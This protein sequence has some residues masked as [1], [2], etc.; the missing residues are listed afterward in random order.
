MN[1]CFKIIGRTP[2]LQEIIDRDYKPEISHPPEAIEEIEV[3]VYENV[4]V[5]GY[6]C[7]RTI[8]RRLFIKLHR[9]KLCGMVILDKG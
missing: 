6:P 1:K 2:E 4:G 5:Q 8:K 3:P 9:C 7:T